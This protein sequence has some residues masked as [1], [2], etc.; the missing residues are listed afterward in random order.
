M[1]TLRNIAA[2]ILMFLVAWVALFTAGKLYKMASIR[3]WVPGAIYKEHVVT[4]KRVLEGTYG[5]VHWLAW[6][7]AD[8]TERSPM[9]ENVE[10]EQ[11]DNIAIGATITMAYYRDDPEP[12]KPDGIFV[13]AG[14]FVFDLLL[15]TLELAAIIGLARYGLTPRRNP[16]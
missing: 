9:R 5:P 15:L 6:S 11:W 12:Y 7:D 10:K 3:G 1:K 2:F 16:T 4:D 13:S 14:N 8:I